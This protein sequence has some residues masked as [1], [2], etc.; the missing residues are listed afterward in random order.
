[1]KLKSVAFLLCLFF[2]AGAAAG[3]E[4]TIDPENA[5]GNIPVKISV[6]D[7]ESTEIY[8]DWFLPV[9]TESYILL[10]M[11]DNDTQFVSCS[12]ITDSGTGEQSAASKWGAL[13]TGFNQQPGLNLSF[14]IADNGN[15]EGITAQQFYS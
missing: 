5:S 11:Y 14:E 10:L 3:V 15:C 4:I 1:M 7:N 9:V 8:S 13:L 2:A 12:L 6:T